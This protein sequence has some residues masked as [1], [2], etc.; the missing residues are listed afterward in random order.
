[1]VLLSHAITQSPVPSGNRILGELHKTILLCPIL[2]DCYFL[3]QVTV[4]LP[5]LS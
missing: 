3:D 1:M 4:R 2:L 5:V